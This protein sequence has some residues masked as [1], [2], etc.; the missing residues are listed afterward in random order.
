[1]K[2]HTGWLGGVL[3]AAVLIAF[4]A[5]RAQEEN[6]GKLTEADYPAYARLRL[7]SAVAEEKR[8]FARTPEQKA[9]VA[10]E[11]LK[12]C[13]D[14][15]WTQERYEQVA[16]AVS[17]ALD[18]LNSEDG[19]E[20]PDL[21]PATVATVKAHRKELEDYSALQQRARQQVQEDRLVA[22]HGVA[23]TAAQLAGKWVLD[24]ALSI[25]SITEGMPDEGKKSSA[26]EY[27]K[28]I[29]GSTYTFGPGDKL[30]ATTQRPN[31]APETQAGAYRLEGATL[32]IVTKRT[33]RDREQ[34]LDIRIKDNQLHIGMMG[35]YSVFLRE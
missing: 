24:V 15:K 11:F 29:T 7:A 25:D 35:I 14:A 10:A 3:V 2:K 17:T 26:E 8:M 12:A 33:N 32:V 18:S 6:A 30:V 1:M 22:S 27:S 9:A 4:T 31:L 34:K 20:Y 21:D 19:S 23:P 16:D 5:A 13:A 28:H